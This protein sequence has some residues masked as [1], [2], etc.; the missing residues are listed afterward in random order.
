MSQDIFPHEQDICLICLIESNKRLQPIYGTGVED[1]TQ[2]IEECGGIKITK[3]AN[4]PDKICPNCYAF[5]KIA[6]KFRVTCQRSQEELRKRVK[7]EV[8]SDERDCFENV[9]LITEESEFVEE[10]FICFND[11]DYLEEEEDVFKVSEDSESAEEPQ[12]PTIKRKYKKRAFRNTQNTQVDKLEPPKKRGRKRKVK[13]LEVLEN[14]FKIVDQ[15][16]DDVRNGSNDAN[17][18]PK[19]KDMLICHH[20]GNK[21]P[22]KQRL[23]AHLKQHK[24][25][26]ERENECEICG[27][28]F[29]TARHLQIHMNTHTGNRPYKCKYCPSAFGDPSSR[30]KHEHAH[31]NIR[32]YKCDVCE[33]SFIYSYALTKHLRIHTGEK[34]FGCSYCQKRFIQKHHQKAHEL[35][36]IKQFE[37]EQKI[38]SE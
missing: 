9:I 33:K 30:I 5:L 29:I 28:R 11:K 25:H 3:E 24:S 1:L 23:H 35:T 26:V 6:H 10:E 14:N 15:F 13:P 19:H 21:Y 2:S 31:D 37:R 7:Q 36:H 8:K 17:A 27:K 18:K 34:P 20:C 32:A 38:L 22:N 4:Y 12:M 16:N